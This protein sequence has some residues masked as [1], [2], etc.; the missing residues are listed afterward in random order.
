MIQKIMHINIHYFIYLFKANA[1]Y[2]G[3]HR[4]VQN[5][6]HYGMSS[7]LVKGSSTTGC[8]NVRSLQLCKQC[9][10]RLPVI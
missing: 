1:G 3:K 7:M 4:A 5:V 6:C 10:L 2:S 8:R 9:H